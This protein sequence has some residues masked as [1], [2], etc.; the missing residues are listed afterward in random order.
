[1]LKKLKTIFEISAGVIFVLAIGA[2]FA[3]DYY[4]K[5]MQKEAARMEKEMF[6]YKE[7]ACSINHANVVAYKTGMEALWVVQ[8]LNP[9]KQFS[10]GY[11]FSMTATDDA[12]ELLPKFAFEGFNNGLIT[13]EVATLGE[14]DTDMVCEMTLS[15]SED[16]MSTIKIPSLYKR[17]AEEMGSDSM[18]AANTAY[19]FDWGSVDLQEKQMFWM[20]FHERLASP[21]KYKVSTIT[22]QISDVETPDLTD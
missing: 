15:M 8:N 12:Q 9:W 1:M 7:T 19:G 21:F 16:F 13:A 18:Y 17:V 3:L 2:Y 6:P 22:G 11:L 10:F 20:V 5:E 4:E 14:D